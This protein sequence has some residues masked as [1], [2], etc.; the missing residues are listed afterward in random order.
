M[1]GYSQQTL[2]YIQMQLLPR[3]KLS[4]RRPFMQACAA[5]GHNG[6]ET[7]QSLSLPAD[8]DNKKAAGICWRQ[9]RKLLR[10]ACVA[11]KIVLF[12]NPCQ[13][14]FSLTFFKQ[15]ET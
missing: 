12:I 1:A 14:D 9:M 5:L 10:F 13:A 4:L 8:S 3:D 2:L 6:L 7:S 15:Y 11:R